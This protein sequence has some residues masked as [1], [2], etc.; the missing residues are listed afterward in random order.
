MAPGNATWLR[1]RLRGGQQESGSEAQRNGSGSRL[2]SRALFTFGSSEIEKARWDWRHSTKC[3][4]R[5]GLQRDI[6]E[7][8]FVELELNS[9]MLSETCE[10]IARKGNQGYIA[11]IFVSAIDPR[12]K[13][14]REREST[15]M[16]LGVELREDL[17]PLELLSW[18]R[19]DELPLATG[20]ERTN[21][22]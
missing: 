16:D 9:T 12:E 15:H 17:F 6:E 7:A 14:V 2:S 21:Q 13:E 3:S 19:S 20:R 10:W 1:L 5:A 8:R 11:C 4:A 22:P 18:T